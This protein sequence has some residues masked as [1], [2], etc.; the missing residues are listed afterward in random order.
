[1]VDRKQQRETLVRFNPDTEKFEIMREYNTKVWFNVNDTLKF[2]KPGYLVY[3]SEES[4]FNHLYMYIRNPETATWATKPLTQGKD[5]IVTG[6]VTVDEPNNLIYFVGT[7]Q[8][9]H[10]DSHLYAVDYSNIDEPK[11][12][13]IQRKVSALPV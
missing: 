8:T 9:A 7:S 13:R 6:S 11:L 12:T 4:G 10:L 2:V 1:L 5:W 3:S